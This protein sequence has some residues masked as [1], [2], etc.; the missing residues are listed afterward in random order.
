M[1]G[2]GVGVVSSEGDGQCKSGEEGELR[3]GGRGGKLGDL[4]D[5][6]GRRGGDPL[7]G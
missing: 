6:E 1:V 7:G 2:V 3:N 4:C 5:E